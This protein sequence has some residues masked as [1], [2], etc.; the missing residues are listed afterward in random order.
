MSFEVLNGGIFSTIQDLGRFGYAYM[1]VTNSGV[2]DE[3][4]YRSV[5]KLLDDNDS[6]ALEI[7]FGGVK[8]R[9]IK[10][11]TIAVCGADLG[12]KINNTKYKIW[13][14]FKIKNGDIIT[15]SGQKNGMRSYLS[16]KGGFIYPKV[17]G[18]Y[19][20]TIR[21][22]IGDKIKSGDILECRDIIFDSKRRI[23]QE[24]IPKYNH[25]LTLRLVLGYQDDYFSDQ[26]KEMFFNSE[27]TLTKDISRMGYKLSGFKMKPKSSNLVSE[28]ICY[29]AVQIP[30][31]GQPIILLKERQTIGGYPKIGSVIPSDC[32]KL[33]QMSI[34]SKIRFKPITI[35]KAMEVSIS[36]L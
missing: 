9:A 22:G 28:G 19:A 20:T 33:S 18:S 36:Y 13:R 17:K 5:L 7:L 31:D 24:Y 34:G 6:N 21:E 10:D 2:M 35:A 30:K 15:F 29:G 32:A 25:E 11:L 14:N 4:A 26:Q 1:G 12:F 27:Y 3:Y 23:K 8:L 16:V